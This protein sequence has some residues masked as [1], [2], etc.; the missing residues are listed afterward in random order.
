MIAKY[1]ALTL[2]EYQRQRARLEKA[3][4]ELRAGG[5]FLQAIARAYY[6]VHATVAYAAA[7]HGITIVH[8]RQGHEVEEDVFTHNS[9]P[10]VL[11]ALYTGNKSGRVRPGSTPGIGSGKLSARTAERFVDMLQ[12]DRKYADYGPTRVLEPYSESVA[13]ERLD[14]AHLIV[15]DLGALT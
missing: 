14:W 13:G 10:D 6:I 4:S 9:I 12:R 3:V 1:P 15:Q 8:T 2:E 7:K 5:S 11:K